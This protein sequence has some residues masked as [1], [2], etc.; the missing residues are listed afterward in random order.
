MRTLVTLCFSLLLTA[1]I[2][3]AEGQADDPN[4]EATPTQAAPEA[5]AVESQ[6]SDDPGLLPRPCCSSCPP[7]DFEHHCWDICSFSC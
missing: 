6:R 5:P 7:D 3:C 4:E 1:S 2:G